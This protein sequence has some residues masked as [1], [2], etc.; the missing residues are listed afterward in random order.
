M[1]DLAAGWFILRLLK[2]KGLEEQ[3]ALRYASVWLLN[4][5]VAN[6]STRGSS[7]GFLCVLIMAL[8]WAFETRRVAL[9]GVLLGLCVH[10]KIYPF[11]YGASMLWALERPSATPSQ[12]SVSQRMSQ[13]VNTNRIILV[14]TS[15]FTFAA[16]NLLMYNIYG[17][18]FLQHTFF[19]HI[20]RIDHRHNFSPYNTL[21]YL[22]S[23][24]AATSLLTSEAR[25]ISFESLAFVPQILLST[26]LIPVAIAKRDLPTAMLAQTLAF[27]TF[28]KVCTSQYFLWYLIFLP[29]YLPNS[30]L[31]RRPALGIT[32]LA[33]WV[34][35]QA[36]WLQQG[37]QLEFLGK[38]TFVPGLFGASLI[39]FAINCWILEIV[40]GDAVNHS[41]R[42]RTSLSTIDNKRTPPMSATITET[43]KTTAALSDATP[44]STVTRPRRDSSV[45]TS[46][47][48]TVHL[49]PRNRVLKSN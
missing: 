34:L 16:L 5:M 37:Y 18:P 46:T 14:L 26:V 6:I 27:V 49:G 11:I 44:K 2:R 47:I 32:A 23:A 7:E 9:S 21:L 24:N 29:L 39:F 40:V 4:P 1:S 42:P 19:H 15:L 45:D 28:N 33:L 22:S 43:K 12:P 3:R 38:S 48:A 17:S 20:T 36:L 35:S 10:L 30:S 25:S 31:R 8:L 41:P 13:F